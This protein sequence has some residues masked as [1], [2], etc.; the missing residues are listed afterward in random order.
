MFI[1][2]PYR[3][4][5]TLQEPPYTIYT[6]KAEAC[7]DYVWYSS[8]NL[9]ANTALQVHVVQVSCSHISSPS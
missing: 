1:F 6:D 4:L 2:I 5:L 3:L 9:N 7:R 8:E